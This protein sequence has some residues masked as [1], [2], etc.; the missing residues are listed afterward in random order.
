VPIYEL[1]APDGRV[2]VIEA[3][4]EQLAMQGAEE[5][6]KAEQAARG[7]SPR[8][9][10]AN[11]KTGD[12]LSAQDP[13]ATAYSALFEAGLIDPKAPKGSLKNPLVQFDGERPEA[14]Q[15]YI[16]QR[17]RIVQSSTLQDDIGQSYVT[18][19]AEAA[20]GL[21]DPELG[22]ETIGDLFGIHGKDEDNGFSPVDILQSGANF[23]LAVGQAMGHDLEGAKRSLATAGANTGAERLAASG[24]DRDPQTGAGKVARLV[25][26]M[27]PGAASPVSGAGLAAGASRAANVAVPAVTAYGGGEIGSAL[28]GESGERIGTVAGGAMGGVLAG[29]R[30]TPVRPSALNT[31]ASR[32]QAEGVPLTPGQKAG[33]ATSIPLVGDVVRGAKVRSVEG[34]NRAVINRSLKPIGEELPKDVKTGREAVAYAG[35]RLS[36]GYDTIL[37]RVVV[38]T[39]PQFNADIAA[40]QQAGASLP[41]AAQAQLARVIDQIVTRRMQG[42]VDGAT[43]KSIESEVGKLAADYSGSAVASERQLGELIGGLRGAIRDQVAR[44]NPREAAALSKLDEGWANLTIAERAAA[45]GKDGVFTP[46]Q[47]RTAMRQGDRSVRKRSTARGEARMQQLID[48]GQSVLP[49]SIPESGTAGRLMA[50]VGALGLTKINPLVGVPAV[51][52]LGLYSKPGISVFNAASQVRP[53]GVTYGGSYITPLISGTTPLQHQQQQ[54]R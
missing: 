10:I 15:F 11:E 8:S 48:D 27:T 4:N 47:A 14:G 29:V 38:Q 44:S 17:G 33:G 24:L 49:S 26:Q 16:D 35:D 37:S 5:W 28:G 31:A 18:G 22:I 25:G 52:V 19:L 39:D 46:S 30:P 32:L 3:D 9:A 2:V 36:Q 13:R 21:L 41:D 50:G 40:I 54:V 34:F 6:Y 42:Q 23:G 45:Q 12:A 1:Q 43:V 53:P 7:A 51:G 20:Q